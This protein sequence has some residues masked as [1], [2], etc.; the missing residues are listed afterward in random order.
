M[1]HGYRADN[2]PRKLVH[3]VEGSAT[4]RT[5]KTSRGVLLYSPFESVGMIDSCSVGRTA[6]ELF[7]GGGDIQSKAHLSKFMNSKATW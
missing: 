5:A 6:D 7:G 3:L 2:Q 4:P 1:N